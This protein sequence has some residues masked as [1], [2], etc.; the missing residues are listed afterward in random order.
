MCSTTVAEAWTI[1]R[2]ETCCVA[3]RQ[4]CICLKCHLLPACLLWVPGTA[5]P[6]WWK[7]AAK[8]QFSLLF[9]WRTVE[10]AESQHRPGTSADQSKV[11]IAEIQ[12]DIYYCL[13]T[14]RWKSWIFK[15]KRAT[16][17]MKYST[18]VAN[19]TKVF[20]Q[21]F[22]VCREILHYAIHHHSYKRQ[23]KMLLT[24]NLN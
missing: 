4:T 17:H 18:G 22:S 1:N 23:R 20:R 19:D 10:S 5:I 16:R 6:V 2:D 21:Q 11:H 7:Q 14:F 3:Q 13:L 12:S 24:S 8:H 9:C 15:E